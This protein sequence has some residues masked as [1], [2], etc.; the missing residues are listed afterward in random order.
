MYAVVSIWLVAVYC[1]PLFGWLL[2]AVVHCLAGCWYTV[3]IVWLVA[4]YCCYCL[5]GCWY[6]VVHCLAGAGILLFVLPVDY[7]GAE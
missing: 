3:V 7:Q 2:Y 4:V 1:C 6:T 5:A